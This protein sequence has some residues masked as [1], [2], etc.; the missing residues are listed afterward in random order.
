M[1]YHFFKPHG[2]RS[3]NS[4][5]FM[6]YVAEERANFKPRFERFSSATRLPISPLGPK[7]MA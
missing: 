7:P 4:V 5:H 1:E 6:R 3:L 2:R